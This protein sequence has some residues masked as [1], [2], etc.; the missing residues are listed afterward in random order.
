MDLCAAKRTELFLNFTV[1]VKVVNGTG[2]HCPGDHGYEKTFC[3]SNS[4]EYNL[5][6]YEYLAIF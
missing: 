1:Q 4:T 5:E 6:L 2:E 3:P